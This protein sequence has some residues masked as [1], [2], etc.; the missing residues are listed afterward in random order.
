MTLSIIGQFSTLNINNT[1]YKGIECIML[2]VIFYC[3][4]IVVMLSANMLNV[5]TLS[6]I[7]PSLVGPNVGPSGEAYENKN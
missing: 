7:I 1:Q 2:S 6:V 3:Y 4:E 5:V